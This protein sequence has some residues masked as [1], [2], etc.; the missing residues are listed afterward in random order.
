MSL[1]RYHYQQDAKLLKWQFTLLALVLIAVIALH[2]FALYLRDDARRTAVA[3]QAN[4]DNVSLELEQIELAEAT[5]RQY[6]DD[7]NVMA[8]LGVLNEEDRV[9]LLEDISRIRDRHSLF[10]ID[11]EIR[12]QERVPLEFPEE[13]DTSTLEE[14]ISLRYSLVQ[15]R[16]PLLHEGDFVKFMTDLLRSGRLMVVESCS[17]NETLTEMAAFYEVVEHMVASCDVIWYTLRREPNIE[18]EY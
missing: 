7:F 2:V 12:E 5:I 6:I 4:F 8:N 1:G 3:Y 9:A 17:L 15:L 13:V 16:V 10:P 11:V 14:V 18:L